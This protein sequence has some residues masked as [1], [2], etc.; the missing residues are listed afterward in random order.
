MTFT[1]CAPGKTIL[2]GEHAVVHNVPAIAAS[3]ALHT[4]VTVQE[5][6]DFFVELDFPHVDLATGWKLED[7]AGIEGY[8][9]GITSELDPEIFRKAREIAESTIN[10]G[11][12]FSRTAATAFLYLY[13]AIYLPAKPKSGLR[14]I[15]SGTLPIGAGLGSSASFSVC[16]AAALLKAS[17]QLTAKTPHDEAMDMVTKWSFLGESC[18]HGKPSGIDNL[19]AT[20]GGAVFF[21]RPKQGGAPLVKL[22]EKFP[23]IG[24]ILTDTCVSRHTSDLVARVA[25]IKAKWPVLF[26]HLMASFEEVVKQADALLSGSEVGSNFADKIGE[27]ADINHGLLTTVG[28]SHPALELVRET[29]AKLG[30]GRTKLTGAGGGG[31][32][33]TISTELNPDISAFRE[34]LHE[35]RVFVTKLG[36][37]GVG[38]ADGPADGTPKWTYW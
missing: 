6:S 3:V 4:F 34:H 16:V 12:S 19:V 18:I 14:F 2:F 36:G 17:G 31:C 25:D 10:A 13:I 9:R 23:E 35:F 27:L 7:F 8:A 21:Q 30:M 5:D 32:A 28:V 29:S 1:I 26:D 38:W 33:I 24:L 15:T 11:N 22:Y 37:A 20:C